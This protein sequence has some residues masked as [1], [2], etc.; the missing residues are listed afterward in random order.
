MNADEITGNLHVIYTFYSAKFTAVL[1]AL[2]Q[3]QRL[4]SCVQ[5]VNLLSNGD[6]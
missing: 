6:W 5:C 1:F 3:S 2:A 4:V